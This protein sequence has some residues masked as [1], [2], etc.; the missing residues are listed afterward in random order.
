M[1]AFYYGSGS[2][3]AWRVWLALEQKR[4][5]YELKLQ[6]FSSGDLKTPE[7]LAINPRGRV[8]AIRDNGFALFESVAIMEYLDEAYD[9]GVPLYPGDAKRRA[10]VR[11]LVQEADQYYAIAMERIVDQVLFTPQERWDLAAIAA[12]RSGLAQELDRWERCVTGA[13]L[14]G[15]EPTAADFTLYP[16]LALTRRMEKKKSDL[17]LAAMTGPA[18]AAWIR[19]MEA[20][21][22]VETTWPPHWKAG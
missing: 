20:L 10:T 6:S 22:I 2:P 4:I 8:P 1:I 13:F 11:R 3:Y 14:A 16:L 12:A 19:R 15:S 18:I 21:P 9:S 5:P 7:Y 17:D